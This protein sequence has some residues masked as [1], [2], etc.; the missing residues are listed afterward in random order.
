MF[1]FIY[2]AQTDMKPYFGKTCTQYKR[3]VFLWRNLVQGNDPTTKSKTNSMAFS[4]QANYTDWATATCWRN[5]VPTF[6]DRGVPTSDLNDWRHVEMKCTCWQRLHVFH[7]VTLL[8][9]KGAIIWV[10]EYYH[11][12]DKRMFPSELIW[13]S[14]RTLGNTY[15]L[16]DLRFSRLWLRT[17]SPFLRSVLRMLV[18]A[19]AVPS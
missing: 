9:R 1:C 18:T 3:N 2:C 12:M 10:H 4:A 13:I 6:A 7:N 15:L 8:P 11:N 19:N 16:Y 5:L 17:T 14:D